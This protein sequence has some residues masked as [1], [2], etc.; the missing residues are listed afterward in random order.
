MQQL[1]STPTRR[2]TRLSKRTR[3]NGCYRVII[4]SLLGPLGHSRNVEVITILSIF[5]ALFFHTT[6]HHIRC[7]DALVSSAMRSIRSTT[8]GR[9]NL[10]AKLSAHSNPTASDFIHTSSSVTLRP[11]AVPFYN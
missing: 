1:R 11:A 8:D 3:R 7:N 4:A 6:H 9:R 5:R 2:D 10:T